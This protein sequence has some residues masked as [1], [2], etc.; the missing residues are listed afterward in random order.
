M[1]APLHDPW[2]GQPIDGRRQVLALRDTMGRE[3][4]VTIF[5][6]LRLCPRHPS[7]HDAERSC[8]RAQTAFEEVKKIGVDPFGGENK[9]L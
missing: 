4:F 3:C 2:F 7:Q 9:P 6:V 8:L 5:D 1:E